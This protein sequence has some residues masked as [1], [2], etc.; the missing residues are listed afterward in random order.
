MHNSRMLE[1]SVQPPDSSTPATDEA[2]VDAVRAGCT[3]LFEELVR[4]HNQRLF[5]AVRCI[6]L[7]D[8]E[9]QDVVQ[10]A[11]VSAF[12]HLAQF[13]GHAKFSTWLTRIAVN[14]A[15]ARARSIATHRRHERFFQAHDDG[16]QRGGRRDVTPEASAFQGELR[17]LLEVA[18]DHLEACHRTVLVL[19]DV[20]G[21]SSREVAECTG[22]SELLVRVRLHRARHQVRAFLGRTIDPAVARPY[23]F[24]GERCA[25]LTQ[26]V[27]T[28]IRQLHR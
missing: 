12:E 13:A 23:A 14:E 22:V 16:W 25:R 18:L 20:E 19:R 15:L 8:D 17:Q 27:L 4:R 9:A 7:N 1:N 6:V 2:L 11:Y 10:Q 5:R 3:A 24:A 21:M 28:S 26:R